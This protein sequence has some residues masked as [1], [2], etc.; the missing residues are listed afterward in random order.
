LNTHALFGLVVLNLLFFASGT[1]LL[2]FLRGWDTWGELA[3]LAGLAYVVGVVSVGSLW[4][5]LLIVGAPFSV[6]IV[7]GVPAG[8]TVGSGLAARRRRR[9]R[10]RGGSI[11]AGNSLIVAAMGISAAGLLIEG[12]FRMSRLSGLYWWD[13]WSFWIP[14]AKAI[15]FFGGLDEQFFTMLPGSSYPP[16]VPVLD[17]AAFQL[18]G[19]PDVVTLHVQYWLFGVGF[20]WA[21]AGLLSERVPAWILWPFMLLLLVAPRIGR[22]FQIT[23]ADLL[24]DYFFVLAAVLVVYWILDG[25]RWQLVAATFLLCGMVLTKREGLLLA[26]VLVATGFLASAR[27][28]RSAWPALGVAAAAVAAVA[29]PWRIWYLVHGVSGEAPTG[30]GL[31]PTENTERL[32]PSFRLAFDVL[33]SSDYWSVIIPVALGALVLAALVRAYVLAVF[34][35]ALVA[36]VTLG[37]GWITWAIPE[38]EITQELRGNPIVRYMGSAALLCAAAS[39]LLLAATWSA[40]T[41]REEVDTT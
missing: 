8:I 2:W 3:R 25:S 7:L 38:L 24:L 12:L 9:A 26:A 39:P 33:L 13:A 10:P 5:L 23:E 15:Y 37:G 36:F 14:K 30:G 20:V 11:G 29:A 17:A 1:G 6:W 31:D 4:T 41:A 16:L 18:M 27:Q 35:G 28:W 34:F 40:V 32:W 21:L 19:S 22:R